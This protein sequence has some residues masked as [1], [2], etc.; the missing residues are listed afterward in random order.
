MRYVPSFSLLSKMASI[1]IIDRRICCCA[2][3]NLV[4]MWWAEGFKLTFGATARAGYSWKKKK[5]FL[6]SRH[7]R[8]SKKEYYFIL[9]VLDKTNLLIQTYH[10]TLRSR[11][12]ENPSN[13]ESSN[14]RFVEFTIH[15]IHDSSNFR[16][17]WKFV[18]LKLMMCRISGSSN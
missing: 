16:S 12:Y 9:I 11:C 2:A 18:L 8:N 17:Y 3:E 6:E 4:T 5:L 15:Q 7:W 13:H 14:S 1:S 10:H